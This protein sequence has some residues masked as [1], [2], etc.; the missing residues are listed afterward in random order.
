MV[1]TDVTSFEWI[2]RS[3][4]T[5]KVLLNSPAIQLPQIHESVVCLRDLVL[6]FLFAIGINVCSRFQLLILI[7]SLTDQKE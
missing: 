4:N 6:C 5:W 7:I 3:L 2:G 1:S